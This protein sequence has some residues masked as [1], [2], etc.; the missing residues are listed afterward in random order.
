MSPE[1]RIKMLSDANQAKAAD[2]Q[3]LKTIISGL[4]EQLKESQGNLNLDTAEI[5]ALML[6]RKA[7][8]EF[9]AIF[10]NPILIAQFFTDARRRG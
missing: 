5:H 3:A 4:L 7:A 2:I 10:P 9:P 6:M 8:G 1:I